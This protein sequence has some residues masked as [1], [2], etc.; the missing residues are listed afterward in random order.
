MSTL[1]IFRKTLSV[2]YHSEK[3][4]SIKTLKRDG[5]KYMNT[6]KKYAYNNVNLSYT[7]IEGGMIFYHLLHKLI[8]YS[9]SG[10][11]F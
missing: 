2:I 11:M 5:L 10:S 9:I 4:R 8:E 3:P 6:M 1:Q 7:Y